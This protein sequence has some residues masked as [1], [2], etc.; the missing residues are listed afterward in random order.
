[1]IIEK[2]DYIAEKEARKKRLA[3]YSEEIQKRVHDNSSYIIKELVEERHR[4]GITGQELSDMI[5]ILPSNLARFE[6]GTRIPTL[7]MLEK[8]AV[9]LGKHIEL[10]IT[11]DSVE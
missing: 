11:S 9:A 2:D 8:Y 4:Q 1:M 5:G 7:V 10:S 3:A 6:N